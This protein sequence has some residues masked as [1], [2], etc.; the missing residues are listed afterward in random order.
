MTAIEIIETLFVKSQLIPQIQY[1]TVQIKPAFA[2]AE[3]N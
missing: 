1:M 3:R 2:H